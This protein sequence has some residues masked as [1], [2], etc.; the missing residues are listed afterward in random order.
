MKTNQNLVSPQKRNSSR[1]L[2]GKTQ[3]W[4]SDLEFLQVEQGFLKAMLSQC[5]IEHCYEDKF[6]TAKLLINSLKHEEELGLELINSIEEHRVNL[7]LLIENIHLKKEDAFR[8]R[9]EYLKIEMKNYVM[10]FKY[11]KQQVY[12]LILEVMKTERLLK[13]LPKA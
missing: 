13:N 2:Y 3:Q 9:H 10:N 12:E 5:V 8:K 7:A 4:S 6:K 11:L 1:F